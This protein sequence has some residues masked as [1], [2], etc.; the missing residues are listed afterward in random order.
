VRKAAEA[1]S[2]SANSFER[3]VMPEIKVVRRGRLVLVPVRELERWMER[4]VEPL[5]PPGT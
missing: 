2:M 3:Y 4:N 5:W 1:L